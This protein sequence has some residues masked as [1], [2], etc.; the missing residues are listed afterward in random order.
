[1]GAAFYFGACGVEFRHMCDVVR[2]L[3]VLKIRYASKRNYGDAGSV[4]TTVGGGGFGGVPAKPQ[5]IKAIATSA[6][7]SARIPPMKICL[8]TT[9]SKSRM[10]KLKLRD[11]RE[12][13]SL[14]WPKIFIAQT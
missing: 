11:E 6:K 3:A 9:A 8:F 4:T 1:L 7:K 14:R 2:P 10:L 12:L 13:N 5:P